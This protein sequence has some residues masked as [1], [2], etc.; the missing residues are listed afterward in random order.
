MVQW[1]NGNFYKAETFFNGVTGW[2]QTHNS[3]TSPDDLQ[4]QIL[5]GRAGIAAV[6]GLTAAHHH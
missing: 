6:V 2:M 5:A 4:V 1:L 3:T